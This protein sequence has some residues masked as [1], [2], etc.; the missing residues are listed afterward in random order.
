MYTL[1]RPHKQKRLAELHADVCRTGSARKL[2][3]IPEFRR[4]TEA[5]RRRTG[6]NF[7]AVLDGLALNMYFD[8]EGLTAEDIHRRV[9]E[10]VREEMQEQ[11]GARS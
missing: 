8:P 10:L 4:N 6:G 11:P 2:D 5:E 9:E 3:L 7:G 1:R